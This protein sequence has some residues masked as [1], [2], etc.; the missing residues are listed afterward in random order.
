MNTV[1]RL[2][3]IF[4]IALAKGV[5][6]TVIGFILSVALASVFHLPMIVI[7]CFS[8]GLGTLKF[9]QGTWAAT[10]NVLDEPFNRRMWNIMH[11][12]PQVV[13]AA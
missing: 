9:A 10:N 1:G 11:P 7:M 12:P 13:A 8:A 3:R 2:E 4:I 5:A 6:V